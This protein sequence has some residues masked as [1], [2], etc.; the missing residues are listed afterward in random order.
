MVWLSDM[1]DKVV[2]Y[3]SLRWANQE[4]EKLEEKDTLVGWI[5]LDGDR[6]FLPRVKGRSSVWKEYWK[7]A[8][9]NHPKTLNCCYCFVEYSGHFV[10]LEDLMS[11]EHQDGDTQLDI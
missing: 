7:C 8:Y 4:G 1:A 11:V 5:G 2:W 3:Q 9:L 10:H 6:F